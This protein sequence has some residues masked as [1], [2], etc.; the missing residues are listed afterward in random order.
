MENIDDASDSWYHTAASGYNQY[1][2]CEGWENLNWKYN[3]FQTVFDFITVS[4]TV[5]KNF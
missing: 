3:G 1:W 4:R 2:D 5:L